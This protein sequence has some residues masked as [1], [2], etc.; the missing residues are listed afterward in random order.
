MKTRKKCEHK[1]NTEVRNYDPIWK[2]GE[3]WCCDCGKKVRNWD[4]G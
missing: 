2:D 1:G 3:V 4:A